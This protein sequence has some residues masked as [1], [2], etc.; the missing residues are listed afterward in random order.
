MFSWPTILAGVGGLLV[1]V[2]LGVVILGAVLRVVPP[3]DQPH[4]RW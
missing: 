4:R 3:A 2:P 1:G